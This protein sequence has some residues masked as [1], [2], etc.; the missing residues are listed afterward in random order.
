M[1][2]VKWIKRF[3]LA[4]QFMTK[5]PISVQLDVDERDFAQSMLFYPIVGLI[6]GALMAG[7]YYI[8]SLIAS[9]LLPPVAAVLSGVAVTGAFHLDGLADVCDALLSNKDRTGMLAVMKDSRIGTGGA[10]AIASIL[11]L[12]IAV[13][14]EMSGNIA[15][16]ALLLAPVLGRTGIVTA[17]AISRYARAEGGLGQHF[18]DKTGWLQMLWTAIIALAIAALAIG[19]AALVLLA[20]EFLTTVLFAKYMKFKIGGMTGDTLGATCEITEVV[21]LLIFSVYM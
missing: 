3:I 19:Y 18:I 10:V 17:A 2:L 16:D 9:G 21:V 11:I 4:V 8:F 5:I 20:A 15:Y 7:V 12:K 1:W 6:V 13:L 14:T